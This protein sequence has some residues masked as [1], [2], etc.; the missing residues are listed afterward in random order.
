MAGE[1]A[2]SIAAPSACRPRSPQAG[3]SG[4]GRTGPSQL[5]DAE[6]RQVDGLLAPQVSQ[7]AEREEQAADHEQVYGHHPLYLG[8]AALERTADEGENGV[9]HASVEGRHEAANTNG[10]KD[11]PLLARSCG[12]RC[13]GHVPILG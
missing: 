8:D 7:A 5:E 4:R 9:D 6:A 2:K 12:N 11:E 3:R 1:L 10:E 13:R